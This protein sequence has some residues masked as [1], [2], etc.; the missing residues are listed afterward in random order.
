L[1]TNDVIL[2]SRRFATIEYE[3]HKLAGLTN[4]P[5]GSSI[6]GISKLQ[7]SAV[8]RLPPVYPVRIN[9]YYT[10]VGA[11]PAK[12]AIFAGDAGASDKGLKESDLD[13]IFAWL[14][15]KLK[16]AESRNLDYEVQPGDHIFYTL[17]SSTITQ[18]IADELNGGK[19]LLYTFALME[20][21][22]ENT[23]PGKFRVTE[24]CLIGPPKGADHF[25]ANHNRVFL[26]D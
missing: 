8:A 12:G 19:G 1:S 6:G 7:Y 15:Y 13:V 16:D 26:S 23:P 10:N 2:P 14:K 4:A 9:I 17:Q 3:D 24:V 25:C 5:T 11:I 18:P 20:Y 21:K 22:D